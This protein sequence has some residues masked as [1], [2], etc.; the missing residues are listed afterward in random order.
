VDGAVKQLTESLEWRAEYKPLNIT[1]TYCEE[2]P[3]YHSW[4]QIGFDKEVRTLVCERFFF[5]VIQTMRSFVRTPL[6][7]F[8]YE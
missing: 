6:I 5:G 7:V 2:R 4:R 3:G 1:C 8:L